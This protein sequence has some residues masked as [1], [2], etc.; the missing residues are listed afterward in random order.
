MTKTILGLCFGLMLFLGLQGK[1]MAEPIHLSGGEL[2][3]AAESPL[4]GVNEIFHM[5]PPR[6]LFLAAGIVGGALFI[7]P[8]LGLNEFLSVIL[9]V[10]TSEYLYRTVYRP[11]SFW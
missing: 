8:S 10:I 5:E 6:L 1:A 7:A 9:G 11:H 4:E 2:I 3:L